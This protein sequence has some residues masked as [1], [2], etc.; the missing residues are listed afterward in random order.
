LSSTPERDLSF[1]TASSREVEGDKSRPISVLRQWLGTNGEIP[2]ASG[3]RRQTFF[4]AVIT[5]AAIVG[6]VNAIN[7]ITILHAHPDA[8][9]IL[10][11]VNEGSSWISLVLFIWIPWLAWRLAPYSA[12]PRWKLLIHIPAAVA[13]AACHVAGFAILRRVAFGVMSGHYV[14]GSLLPD[15][16]YELRK[17]SLGYML[18][19]FSFTLID[20]LLRQQALIETPGQTL[21]FDIRDG[22]KLTRVKLDEI[23]AVTSAGNYVEFALRDGRRLLMRSPLSVLENELSPRGFLR[24]HRSWLVNAKSV[25]A[26]KPE[27][28]GDY[29]IELGGIAAPLSRRFPEALAKLRNAS[30]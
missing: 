5:A 22:A 12:R 19:F 6:V 18:F 4:Y 16:F 7:V 2:G 21:T 3:R 17:D 30:V 24:T 28:S 25:T 29:T 23:L 26:L 10:P 27:G 9:P 11:I 20:H 8:G 1:R 14:S 15:F 13:F